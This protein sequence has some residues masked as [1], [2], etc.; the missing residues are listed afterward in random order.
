MPHCVFHV[1]KPLYEKI[2]WS[3]ILPAFNE[4]LCQHDSGFK[5][6][7]CKG[8][9]LCLEDACI[10]TTTAPVQRDYVHIE[11]SILA[12]RAHELRAAISHKMAD[13][14]FS[15]L[16]N[17]CDIPFEL[18]VTISELDPQIYAKRVSE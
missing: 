16:R 11:I 6:F 9:V 3:L 14:A 5:S 17:A 10:G 2:N 18:T 12:G 7:A 13:W 4:F 8:R 1:T 15:E